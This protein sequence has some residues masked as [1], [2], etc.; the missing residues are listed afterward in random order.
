MALIVSHGNKH[1][2]DFEGWHGTCVCGCIFTLQKG[3]PVSF[4]S[5]RS[6]G[7]ILAYNNGAKT[8]LQA[9]AIC[10]DCGNYF[11]NVSPFSNIS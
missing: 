10:P 9:I 6:D 3:D 11:G 7:I 8:L 2:D 4:V 5:V 1:I